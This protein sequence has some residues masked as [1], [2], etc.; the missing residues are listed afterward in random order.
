MANE[1]RAE[2]TQGVGTGLGAGTVPGEG[3]RGAELGSAVSLPRGP[4]SWPLVAA[5]P[6]PPH[7]GSPCCPL[8][9]S[10][11]GLPTGQLSSSCWT[12][13]YCPGSWRRGEPQTKSR[14]FEKGS[15]PI[16]SWHLHVLT[17]LPPR[18]RAWCF[19]GRHTA[20]QQGKCLGPHCPAEEIL[21]WPKSLFGCLCP[22]SCE[23]LIINYAFFR[24]WTGGP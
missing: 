24:N 5:G 12:L 14:S 20:E 22:F 3:G 16:P 18:C 15:R 17:P 7:P 9:S 11:R 1:G 4:W 10:D 13:L 19:L 23:L 8:T 6:V 2:V 21:I